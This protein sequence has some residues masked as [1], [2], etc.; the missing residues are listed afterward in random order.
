MIAE[1]HLFFLTPLNI[2][3]RNGGKNRIRRQVP[4]FL[5]SRE[6]GFSRP[7]E[8]NEDAT[9]LLE[10]IANQPRPK[11]GKEGAMEK[12]LCV[13]DD[14][15]LLHL[16]RDE[17]SEEGYS[18]ILAKDGKEAMRK[19]GKESPDVVVMDICMPMMEG[20]QTMAAMQG[21]DRQVPVILNTAS[22]QYKDDFM[23]WGAEAYVVKSSDLTE[24]THKMRELLKMRKKPR[25]S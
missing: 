15:I 6:E 8:Q 9:L 25:R 20:I 24:L 7:A 4:P 18:V 14:L 12:V 2:T 3:L 13:D 19:F 5:Q 17:L 21:N 10:K 11:G 23:T 1:T 22:P 16:Y